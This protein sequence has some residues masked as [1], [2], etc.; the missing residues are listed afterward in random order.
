MLDRPGVTLLGLCSTQSGPFLPVSTDF[1]KLP[2]TLLSYVYRSSA[3][4]ALP[5][6]D[7]VTDHVRIPHHT[8]SKLDIFLQ[9]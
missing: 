9:V 5:M 6:F 3:L 8:K 7:N 2:N 1:T 4:G